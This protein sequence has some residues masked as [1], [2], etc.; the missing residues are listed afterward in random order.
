[1]VAL[2]TAANAPTSTQRLDP[3]VS[4][5]AQYGEPYRYCAAGPNA[6]DCRGLTYYSFPVKSVTIPRTSEGHG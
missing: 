2:P 5:I 1:V 4:P 6:F 3:L